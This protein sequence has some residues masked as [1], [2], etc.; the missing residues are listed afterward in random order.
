MF[1]DSIIIGI[2]ASLIMG[3]SLQQLVT[4]KLNHPWLIAVSFIIQFGAIYI[5][6]EYLLM[7]VCAS[8]IGLLIFCLVNY[9]DKGFKYMV[10]GIFMNLLVMLANKG[11]MPVDVQAAKALSP[12]DF[13]AFM[14]GEYGKHIPISAH[15]HLNFLGDIFFLQYPYPRPIIISLGD[16][17]LSI[18]VILFLYK[19]MA[20]SNK[21]SKEV[22]GYGG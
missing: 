10:I 9:K 13:P 16:I 3:G 20:K 1:V 7:S 17:V 18:G 6:L 14:A 8:N 11:R 22:V 15:T 2:I 12:E 21:K 4:V 5:F 19:A